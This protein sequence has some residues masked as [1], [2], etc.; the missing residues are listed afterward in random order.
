M[1]RYDAVTFDM[2]STL[3]YFHPSEGEVYLR[4]FRSIG[5]DPDPQALRA[6]R[7]GVWAQYFSDAHCVTYEASEAYDRQLEEEMMARVL[8]HLGLNQA[9]LAARVL[10]AGK[11]AFRAPGAVRLYPD[12][13]PTLQAL[14]DHGLRLGVISNWSWDL[15]DYMEMLGLTSSF[16]AVVA[17]ARAG[18]DKPHP[19]IFRQALQALGCTP[20]RAI[21]VGDSYAADVLGARGV[22]MDA[23]WLDRDGNDGHPD[24]RTI[25]DLREVLPAVLEGRAGLF[26]GG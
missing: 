23:L 25:R 16:E 9:G 6:A 4:A 14:R 15:H 13:A 18:C 1:T 2:G 5:L 19:A 10:A 26:F 11:V 24:C 21:H 8:Q 17:S 12:V 3:V 20:E 22:G 7:D